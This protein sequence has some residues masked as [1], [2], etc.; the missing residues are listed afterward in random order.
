M[1]LILY[2]SES[3]ISSTSVSIRIV[4]VPSARIFISNIPL[5]TAFVL[6]KFTPL[7]VPGLHIGLIS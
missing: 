5:S 2:A 7:S 1:T 6:A 4:L 3:A